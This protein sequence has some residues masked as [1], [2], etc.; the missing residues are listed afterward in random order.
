[1]NRTHPVVPVLALAALLVAGAPAR[2][3][4][5]S[6]AH[7]PVPTAAAAANPRMV[8]PFLHDD[9]SRAMELARQRHLPVFVEAWAPW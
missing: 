6:A 2:A 7:A 5:A 3:H 4:A 9:W 1:M 8:L